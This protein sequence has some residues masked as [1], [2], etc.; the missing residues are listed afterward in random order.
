MGQKYNPRAKAD[1]HMKVIA[2][3]QEIIADASTAKRVGKGNLCR[4]EGTAGGFVKFGDDSV[5]VPSAS[6]KET[7]KT[8][9]GFFYV[10]ATDD[11]IRTSAAMRI[12][13]IN[14]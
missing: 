8:E 5:E 12:E 3:P 1:K 13:V 14:D 7:I 2:V 6:T 4:I 10:V 9:S 11:F